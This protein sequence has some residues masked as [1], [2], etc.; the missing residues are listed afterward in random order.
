MV[1]LVGMVVTV[2]QISTEVCIV[3]LLHPTCLDRSYWEGY[4]KYKKIFGKGQAMKIL[5]NEKVCNIL[6][7]VVG[8]DS[9]RN[10]LRLKETLALLTQV[11]EEEKI[12][13]DL[14]RG[15]SFGSQD[16]G[17]NISSSRHLDR[18]GLQMLR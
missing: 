16:I 2:N 13:C 17:H 12:D 10:S 5:Q 1:R 4:P 6:S 9:E 3:S 18:F 15:H 8:S 11:V 14:W 7:L